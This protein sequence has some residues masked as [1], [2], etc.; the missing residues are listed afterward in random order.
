MLSIPANV[1]CRAGEPRRLM[2]RAFHDLWPAE[3]RK[4]RSKD[5]FGSV[6]LGSLR[7]LA[8][9]LLKRPRQMQVVERGYV[10]VESIR[11][12]LEQLSHSLECNESQLRQIILLEFWLRSRE[13]RLRAQPTSLS[14]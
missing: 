13:K 2:R 11:K 6:F 1:C 7:P 3:L 10:E 9:E 4:R 5:S 12:R 14:A 8:N